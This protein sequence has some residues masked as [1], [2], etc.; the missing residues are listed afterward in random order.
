MRLNRPLFLLLL[1][2][3]LTT[4]GVSFVDGAPRSTA[5]SATDGPPLP[6]HS[7]EAQYEKPIIFFREDSNILVFHP[8]GDIIHKGRKVTNDQDIVLALQ[9]ILSLSPCRQ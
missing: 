9:E 7:L 3:C 8:N 5:H 4:G 2:S 6:A 1:V